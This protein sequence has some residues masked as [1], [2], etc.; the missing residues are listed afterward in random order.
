MRMTPPVCN[1]SSIHE[2]LYLVQHLQQSLMVFVFP[3]ALAAGSVDQTESSPPSDFIPM[4][5]YAS[6]IS[7]FIQ[8]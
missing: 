1:R 8:A 6:L 4:T 7:P 2:C 3:G 5:A